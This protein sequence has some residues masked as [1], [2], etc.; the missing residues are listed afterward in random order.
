[1]T[2]N[3]NLIGGK[4]ENKSDDYKSHRVLQDQDK[5]SELGSK[6]FL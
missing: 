1:M 2:S 6:T 3:P 4:P 5:S